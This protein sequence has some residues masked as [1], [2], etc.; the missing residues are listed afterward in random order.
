LLGVDIGTSGTKTVLFTEEG[1]A[2]ASA[3]GNIP[4]TSLRTAGRSRSGGLVGSGGGHHCRGRL[5]TRVDPKEIRG[6]GLSGQMHGLVLL[7]AQGKAL[8]RSIIW[9]DGA[10]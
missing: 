10:P 2:V 1:K 6:V 3:T 9:C 7:N 4:F 5:Q 8:R